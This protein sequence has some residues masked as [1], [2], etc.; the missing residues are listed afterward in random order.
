[1]LERGEYD[2]IHVPHKS[3][4]PPSGG[5]LKREMG[6][7]QAEKRWGRTGLDQ[8][9]ALRREGGRWDTPRSPK[10]KP[11]RVTGWAGGGDGEGGIKDEARALW[12]PA[13]WKDH[14]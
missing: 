11:W 7:D 1:M 4:S 3:L 2:Q 10:D 8:G 13:V 14:P 6:G 12:E 5:G 9:R